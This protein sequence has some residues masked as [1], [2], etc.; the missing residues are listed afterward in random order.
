MKAQTTDSKPA[1]KAKAKAPKA[2]QTRVAATAAGSDTAAAT[3]R[4]EVTR[5]E[6]T[7]PQ[8]VRDTQ[9][10]VSPAERARLEA[11]ARATAALDS[12]RPLVQEV[13]EKFDSTKKVETQKKEAIRSLNSATEALQKIETGKTTFADEAAKQKAIEDLQAR[14]AKARADMQAAQDAVKNMDRG[15]YFKAMTAVRNYAA[16]AENYI[17]TDSDMAS[18]SAFAKQAVKNL[19]GLLDELPNSRNGV[20]PP[21]DNLSR[22]GGQNDLQRLSQIREHLDNRLSDMNSKHEARNRRVVAQPAV[23]DAFNLVRTGQLR[24]ALPGLLQDNLAASQERIASGSK[25]KS[26]PDKPWAAIQRRVAAVDTNALASDPANLDKVL[27][28]STVVFFDREGRVIQDNRGDGKVRARYFDV[29]KILNG[30]GRGGAGVDRLQ[31][32]KPVGYAVIAPRVRVSFDG[33]LELEQIGKK[34]N[35]DP[36]VAKDVLTT[37]GTVPE[38]I[39]RGT[40]L[41]R[42]LADYKNARVT[43]TTGN[44]ASG[45]ATVQSTEQQPQG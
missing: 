17:A 25:P 30:D 14:Q 31:G 21:A 26:I 2:E 33:T 28:N 39:V 1:P 16:A 13:R 40:S 27:Q 3:A 45:D 18:Q 11:T 8:A 15:P 24:E 35:G 42:I 5:S 12:A 7:A 29:P 20:K 9:P 43:G 36:I 19:E 41:G 38:G 23:S 4:T 32:E 22:R 44:G 37:G 34:T 6:Q 10:E